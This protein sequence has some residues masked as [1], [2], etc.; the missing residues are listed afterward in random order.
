MDVDNT[1]RAGAAIFLHSNGHIGVGTS[2]PAARVSVVDAGATELAGTA[3]SAVLRTSAGVLGPAPG[4]ETALST[5]GLVVD[6]ANNVG[7]GI[8]AVRTS[9][10]NGWQ[11]TALGLGMD[12]DNTVRA[13]AAMFLHSNGNIGIGNSQ[14]SSKLTVAGMISTTAGGV[15]FP[16]GSVQTTASLRGLQGPQG[17]PGPPGPPTRTS[18]VCVNGDPNAVGAILCDCS[19][20]RLISRVNSNCTVTSDTGSCSASSAIDAAGFTRNGSCCVCAP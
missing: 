12:V 10:G 3:H 14:P 17:P 8:R 1:V 19:G 20:G 13:G 6:N 11:T 7:L 18:A 9:A 4:S 2:R 16:D 15:R 5:H